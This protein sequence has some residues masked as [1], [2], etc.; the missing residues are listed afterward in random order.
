MYAEGRRNSS[1]IPLV[2]GGIKRLL[3]SWRMC[4]R[5]PG[6]AGLGMD[7]ATAPK[8]CIVVKGLILLHEQ[9][10]I[11]SGY[12]WTGR[13]SFKGDAKA[14]HAPRGRVTQR[15]WCRLACG[16]QA[17]TYRYSSTRGCSSPSIPSSTGIWTTRTK[18]EGVRWAHIRH[19]GHS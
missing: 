6:T 11:P 18:P 16:S 4:L 17:T 14:P 9:H 3:R 12:V 8:T 19:H 5:R 1:L 13:G 10:P 7:K 15:R 2:R